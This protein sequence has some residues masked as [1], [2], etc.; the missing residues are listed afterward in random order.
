MILDIL[1]F[2]AFLAAIVAAIYYLPNLAGRMY[3]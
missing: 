3:R 2:A 1:N